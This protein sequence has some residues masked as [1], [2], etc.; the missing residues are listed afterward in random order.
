AKNN[1]VAFQ[2]ALDRRLLVAAPLY[3]INENATLSRDGKLDDDS[4][5]A[6]RIGRRYGIAVFLKTFGTDVA[7]RADEGDGRVDVYVS[8]AMTRQMARLRNIAGA[9]WSPNERE[10]RPTLFAQGGPVRPVLF[11]YR[12]RQAE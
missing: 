9:A 6:Q 12:P 11:A 8:E 3:Q 5:I 2:E 7:Y 4:R 10:Y 1:P